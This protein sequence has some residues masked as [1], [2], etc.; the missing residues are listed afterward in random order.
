M[1]SITPNPIPFARMSLALTLATICLSLW[2]STAGAQ[3]FDPGAPVRNLEYE[4]KL[5]PI[6][7][8][9]DRIAVF[10][11]EGLVSAS[12]EAVARRLG[13]L[14]HAEPIVSAPDYRMEVYGTVR[15]LDAGALLAAIAQLRSEPS[16]ARAA[17]VYESG[18]MMAIIQ[19]HLFVQLRDGVQE[20]RLRALMAPLGLTLV[21]KTAWREG[22]YTLRIPDDGSIDAIAAAEAL[23]AHEEIV[24]AEPDLI[25]EGPALA[26]PN[27]PLF[28]PRQWN[29]DNTNQQAAWRKD[30]DLDAP[31][32]WEIARAS[33]AV[34]VAVLDD[35]FQ[36][37][38]PDY[39]INLDRVNAKDFVD[40]D[41][42]PTPVGIDTHGTN[43][44]GIAA[45]IRDNGVGIA[46]V[47]G[48]AKILPIRVWGGG[49][50]STQA[51]A[52]GIGWAT[53]KG[54]SVISNS[55]HTINDLPSWQ[56][57]AAIREAVTKGRAGRGCV[58][59]FAAG[60][61]DAAQLAWPAQLE[62]VISVGATNFCDERKSDV[63]LSCDG[64]HGWGSCYGAGL[65]VAAP[66]VSIATTTRGAATDSTSTE[67]RQPRLMSRDS[68]RC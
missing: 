31:E 57:A 61:V 47:A 16:V 65:D 5:Y 63:P 2:A 27:D 19:D 11:P 9:L 46:G 54:A 50:Y 29:L 38:H 53:M 56:I 25:G 6:R 62:D 17:P 1:K 26:A 24:Y 35:G 15:S 64:E 44:L 20:E 34:T 42:I 10:Y 30:D 55:W 43:C 60:N 3:V 7:L 21:E 52:D 12:R 14:V 13:P 41:S 33:L 4:G 59:V 23:R 66:G 32:A 37:D 8:Q 48:G 36:M 18:G 68:R 40:G 67:P 49:F 39:Q 22:N 28:A 58:V 45:A 51:M